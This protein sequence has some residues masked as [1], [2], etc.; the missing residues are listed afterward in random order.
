MVPFLKSVLYRHSNEVELLLEGEE[1]DTISRVFAALTPTIKTP[2]RQ[3]TSEQVEHLLQDNDSQPDSSDNTDPP[4]TKRKPPTPAV[5]PGQSPSQQQETANRN[6]RSA[7][8][9]RDNRD[10]NVRRAHGGRDNQDRAEDLQ[11]APQIQVP[12]TRTG[13]QHACRHGS[14][15]LPTLATPC[16]RLRAR[17]PL[18]TTLLSS[19]P[20]FTTRNCPRTSGGMRA[21]KNTDRRYSAST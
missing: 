6:V 7:H 16:G 10:P 4:S 8:G 19:T 13:R 14:P 11:N 15:I 12:R 5:P 18:A 9:G 3:L 2:L 21:Q 1:P 20:T 17:F